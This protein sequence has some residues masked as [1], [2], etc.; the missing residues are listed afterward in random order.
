M[1]G[2]V[3]L[4]GDVGTL[5]PLLKAGEVLGVGKNTVFGFGEY[6]VT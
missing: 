4:S 3:R 2:S 1:T 5:M 6:V